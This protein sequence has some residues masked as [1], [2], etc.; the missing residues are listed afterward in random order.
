MIS[1]EEAVILFRTFSICSMQ[2]PILSARLVDQPADHRYSLIIRTRTFLEPQFI[3]HVLDFM[4]LILLSDSAPVRLTELA[5]FKSIQ[6]VTALPLLRHSLVLSPPCLFP[7]SRAFLITS[8]IRT[9]IFVSDI[10]I[11]LQTATLELLIYHSR[12]SL[13][14]SYSSE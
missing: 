11:Y 8:L 4:L 13:V 3:L 1:R 9:A 7:S 10:A 14:R 6:V 5:R 12:A 2:S